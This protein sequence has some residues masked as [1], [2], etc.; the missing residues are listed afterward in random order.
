M[1]ND[2]SD[3]KEYLASRVLIS[4]PLSKL[5][6]ESTR[7]DGFRTPVEILQQPFLWR[8]TAARM[9]G[10]AGPL[11]RFL[12]RAGLYRKADR[13]YILFTGAGTSD[14]AGLSLVDLF[15]ERF[16]TLA[17]NY[18]T[19]RITACPNNGLIRDRPYVMIHF[20]RSG[21]SPES[22]AVLE[23]ALRRRD[24]DVRHIVITCNRDGDLAN[25]ARL[26]EGLVYLIVLDEATHDN[27]LAMTSSFT[28]M[29][30]AA[31]AITHLSDMGSF[32][33]LIDRI[34]SAAEHLIDAHAGRISDLAATDMERA[35]FLG[36][37]DL[38]G[39][40]AECA[41]KLQELTSGDVVA[42]S[43]DPLGF[44][45]GPIS[46]VG[47][48]SLVTLLLSE[49]PFTRRYELDVVL[50]YQQAFHDMCA[51]AVLLTA[52]DPGPQI[53]SWIK[54]FTYDPEG[55]FRIPPLFQVNIAVL[56][57]QMLGM[58]ASLH[59]GHNVD[60]PSGSTPLYSRTVQGVT[61]YELDAVA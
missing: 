43:D 18:P 15:R 61:V 13:P 12:E 22:R 20:A 11:R 60:D 3:L 6:R 2:Q 47:C 55:K 10:H 46:A 50:Q 7:G 36:N 45:H 52:S 26:H 57:G 21:N 35:F 29:V 17:E 59:G 44:R 51:Q 8:D 53:K 4:N 49:D 27:A 54:V 24:A 31:Q 40:A 42:K 23:M 5:V 37:N 1:E 19:T 39:A 30:V 48:N 32:S 34:A 41:L 25:V 14:Y 58:F 56:F 9:V 38:F 28:S 16:G 33:D